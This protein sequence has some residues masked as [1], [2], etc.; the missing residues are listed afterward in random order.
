MIYDIDFFNRI[1]SS[2]WDVKTLTW[3]SVA[4]AS[5]MEKLLFVISDCALIVVLDVHQVPKATHFSTSEPL[6]SNEGIILIGI[7]YFG[8]NIVKREL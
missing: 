7:G 3:T 1:P 4:R 8:A 6:C 5:P 2:G